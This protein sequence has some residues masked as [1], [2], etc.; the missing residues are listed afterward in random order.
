LAECLVANN[1]YFFLQ[2]N[3]VEKKATMVMAMMPIVG[4]YQTPFIVIID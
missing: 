2:E 3:V 1:L 4:Q